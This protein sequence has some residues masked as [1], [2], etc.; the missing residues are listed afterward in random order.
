MPFNYLETQKPYQQE[1]SQK[2]DFT[3]NFINKTIIIFISHRE[4]INN[5]FVLK[6][7]YTSNNPFK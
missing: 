1:Q 6:Q 2:S 5:K 7:Y 3:N 4:R